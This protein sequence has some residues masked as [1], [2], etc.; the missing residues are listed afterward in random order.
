MKSTLLLFV[1]IAVLYIGTA[2]AAEFV[3]PL[4]IPKPPDA[5][6]AISDVYDTP[7]GDRE[8]WIARFGTKVS[9]QDMISFYRSALEEAGFR[10]YSSADRADYAMIAAKKGDDRV[11]ISFK[12]QSDWV[13]AEENEIS[14]KAVYNK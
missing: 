11:T 14:I 1:Y 8:E 9:R 13:E 10:I 6:L 3:M 12:S 2:S 4:G 7:S 5:R